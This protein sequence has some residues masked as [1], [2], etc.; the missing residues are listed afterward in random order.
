MKEELL[1]ILNVIIALALGFGIVTLGFVF[2][3][4]GFER[5]AVIKPKNEIEVIELNKTYSIEDFFVFE[6]EKNPEKRYVH[7][8]I[9]LENGGWESTD[10]KNGVKPKYIKLDNDGNFTITNGPGTFYLNVC[11]KNPD[12]EGTYESVKLPI[13]SNDGTTEE[14]QETQQG[15]Q[16]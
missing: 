5:C 16:Q 14:Q 2:L 10:D 3:I 1:N 6:N 11:A 15:R 9:E 7:I 4:K 8:S 13:A 12:A